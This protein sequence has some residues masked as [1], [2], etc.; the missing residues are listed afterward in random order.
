MLIDQQ[1]PD[2]L[3]GDPVKPGGRP[4]YPSRREKEGQLTSMALRWP[5]GSAFIEAVTKLDGKANRDATSDF[6]N[7][8][9]HAIAPRFS[10]GITSP[11]TRTVEQATGY[12]QQADGTFKDVPIDGTTVSYGVGG[13]APLDMRS[14]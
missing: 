12:E 11:V 9:S 1:I 2:H 5:S 10:A 3:V 8:A 7:R 13:I 6:R 4:R 14:A